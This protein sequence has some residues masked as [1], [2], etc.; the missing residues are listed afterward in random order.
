MS[1]L[2]QGAV[3][4]ELPVAAARLDRGGARLVG[5]GP[6]GRAPPEAVRGD[7]R[8]LTGDGKQSGGAVPLRE[9]H[10]GCRDGRPVLTLRHDGGAVDLDA[11]RPG[12]VVRLA[13]PAPGH[14]ALGSSGETAWTARCWSLW[15]QARSAAGAASARRLR[16]SDPGAI[17]TRCVRAA[18][19]GQRNNYRTPSTERRLLPTRKSSAISDDKTSVQ[20]SW[21]KARGSRTGHPAESAA[22]RDPLASPHG[23]TGVTERLADFLDGSAL[24]A[25]SFPWPIRPRNNCSTC[26]AVCMLNVMLEVKW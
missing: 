25:M 8:V 4:A 9:E 16:R 14:R 22:L 24:A 1:R 3:P 19:V 2:E 17:I 23:L 21:G 5:H 11:G 15:S 12:A 26:V 10:L 13:L 6:S 20:G 18:S 7:R